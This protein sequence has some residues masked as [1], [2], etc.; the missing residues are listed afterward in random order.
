MLSSDRKA[1]YRNAVIA[2]ALAFS[3][4]LAGCTARPLYS[5]PAIAAGAEAGAP[6]RL[7]SIA[8]K[9]VLSREAQQV[10]NH[11]I[12]LLNGGAEQPSS[13]RYQVTL[14]VTGADIA[15]AAV[16]ADASDDIIASAGG[17]TMT[18]SYLV[19]DTVTGEQVASGNRSVNAS[20]DRPGQQF[21]DTRARRDA[22][23]RA[24][25]ELAEFVRLSLLQDLA[26]LGAQ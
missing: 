9:P 15:V 25:R 6:A 23:N 12:F 14:V 26:R 22:E 20:Y 2:A 18:A 16:Q 3:A 11:L 10:R 24:A 7:S 8:V 17:L 1:P 4:L 13:P 5:E 21:A 19:T